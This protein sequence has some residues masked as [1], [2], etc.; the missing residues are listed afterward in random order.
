LTEQ[1]IRPLVMQ[2]RYPLSGA[3]LINASK[4]DEGLVSPGGIKVPSTS[5]KKIAFHMNLT[6]LLEA[7]RINHSRSNENNQNGSNENN[8]LLKPH[9]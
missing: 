7:K 3:S 9:S 4:D 5:Q 6:L 2:K 8:Q 1:Y